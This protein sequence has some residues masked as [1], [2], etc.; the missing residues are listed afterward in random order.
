MSAAQSR[1]GVGMSYPSL[2]PTERG[3]WMVTISH[4]GLERTV[5]VCRSRAA[6]ESVCRR[7]LQAGLAAG[8]TRRRSDG[9]L[10]SGHTASVT[11]KF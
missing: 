8:V 9:A 6:A 11:R 5:T 2:A 3:P 7:L 10:A 1:R 4:E